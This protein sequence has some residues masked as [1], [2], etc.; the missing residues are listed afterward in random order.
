MTWGSRGPGRQGGVSGDPVRDHLDKTELRG[1]M[2]RLG[3]ADETAL[4]GCL[5]LADTAGLSRPGGSQCRRAHGWGGLARW[6]TRRWSTAADWR[7]APC[8]QTAR[9][10]PGG[11]ARLSRPRVHH[12]PEYGPA[13]RAGRGGA[14]RRVPD[15]TPLILIPLDTQDTFVTKDPKLST[16]YT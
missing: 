14:A 10:R 8:A 6:P 11:C 2:K 15:R 3:L 5:V 7:A 16:Q 12:P 13:W 1:D 9:A 4:A